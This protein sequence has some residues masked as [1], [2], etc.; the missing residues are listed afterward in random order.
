MDQIAHHLTTTVTDVSDAA[1]FHEVGERVVSGLAFLPEPS[2]SGDVLYLKPDYG[3]FMKWVVTTHPELKL[4]LPPHHP[5]LVLHSAD[6]WLPLMYIARDTSMQVLLGLI[7]NYLYDR[8]KGGLKS[9]RPIIAFS[10]VYEDRMAQKTKRLDFKGA[11][12]D[13]AKVMKKFDA[14]NFFDGSL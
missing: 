10:I 5:K 2:S 7:T 1:A 4:A 13:L 12:E 11:A 14:N 6:I 3:D 8:M 9:D